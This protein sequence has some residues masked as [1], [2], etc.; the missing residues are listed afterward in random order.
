MY[1]TVKD[2]KDFSDFTK[3]VEEMEHRYWVFRGH[4]S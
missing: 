3:F 2:I 4:S 1:H